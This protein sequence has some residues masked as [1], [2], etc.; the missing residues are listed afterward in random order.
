MDL[1]KISLFDSS[2]YFDTPYQLIGWVGWFVIVALILWVVRQNLEI[3]RDKSFWLT[4]ILLGI[5]AILAAGLIG[6]N[7]PI[8]TVVP[9]PNVPSDNTIP[10]VMI[11]AMVPILLSGGLL[12]VWPAAVLGF[13]SGIISA[14]WNTHSVFT[15]LEMTA[16]AVLLALCLRQEYRTPLFSFIRR[17]IGAIF[18]VIVLSVPVYLISSFLARMDPWLLNWIT[19]SLVRGCWCWSMGC[20]Y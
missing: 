4:F 5:G 10:T 2:P 17:P 3:K 14:L 12:G 7:L 19:P 11:F 13:I 16:F 1:I 9:F 18:A 20:S 8:K 15:P 6:I